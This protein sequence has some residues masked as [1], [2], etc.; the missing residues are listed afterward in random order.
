MSALQ[1]MKTY[2][3]T[4][5]IFL[6]VD[7]IWLGLIAKQFYQ[8]RLGH[9]FRDQVNWYA[10]FLF[11]LIFVFGILIFVVSPSLK[12]HAWIHALLMGLV[13]GLVTYATFDLTSLALFRG[14]TAPI[15][16]VDILWGAALSGIV[17]TVGYFIAR[18]FS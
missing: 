15:V 4:F 17:S 1:W 12:S 14:W 18:W 7:F 10:A 5:L 11:Y 13:F 2:V 16:V 8:S 6:A 9:L 3:L